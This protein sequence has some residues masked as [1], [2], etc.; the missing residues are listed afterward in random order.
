MWPILLLS[1]VAG[2]VVLDSR[3]SLV[4]RLVIVV[5]LA[6]ALLIPI[7]RRSH[8]DLHSHRLHP[9]RRL[10]SKAAAS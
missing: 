1:I 10:I 7:L 9:A 2:G 8:I 5:D 3:T 6:L 4:S